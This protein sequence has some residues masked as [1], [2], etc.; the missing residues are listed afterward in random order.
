MLIRNARLVPLT[1]PAPQ[2][3]V[4]VLVED[5]HPEQPGPEHHPVGRHQGEPVE[6]RLRRHHV[7]TMAG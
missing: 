4:D 3:L 6:R 1:E 7:P 2:G 5:G